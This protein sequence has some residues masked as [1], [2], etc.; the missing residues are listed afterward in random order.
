MILLQRGMMA[1]EIQACP[2]MLL[3]DSR[4]AENVWKLLEVRA[5]KDRDNLANDTER[6]E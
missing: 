2:A 4:A 6:V 5:Q 1:L 3:S